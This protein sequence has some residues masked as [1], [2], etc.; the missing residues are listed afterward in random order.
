[1]GEG[2]KWDKYDDEH[3]EAARFIQLYEETFLDET[4]E[5]VGFARKLK[6]IEESYWGRKALW[7]SYLLVK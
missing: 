3:A 7:V 4:L 1:M 2:Q 5:K 6:L